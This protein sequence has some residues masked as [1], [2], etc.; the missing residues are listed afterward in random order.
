MDF[1]IKTFGSKKVR[2]SELPSDW[3]HSCAF[4]ILFH[5][6]CPEQT[7]RREPSIYS[8]GSSMVRVLR[9][10]PVKSIDTDGTRFSA[11]HALSGHRPAIVRVGTILTPISTG[12][13]AGEAVKPYKCPHTPIRH[14]Q[15]HPNV[16]LTPK[17]QTAREGGTLR[18]GGT[19]APPSYPE[20]AENFALLENPLRSVGTRKAWTHTS[21]KA[22]PR[23]RAYTTRLEVL[24][25][26]PCNFTA[27]RRGDINVHSYPGTRVVVGGEKQT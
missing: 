22:K 26:P 15:Q 11:G 3:H 4:G 18:R 24:H 16:P 7:P 17:T 27:N 20:L 8:G 9:L 10:L 21:A 5:H 12:P 19:A 1:G 23:S 25:Q 13:P 2:G 6:L 14:R